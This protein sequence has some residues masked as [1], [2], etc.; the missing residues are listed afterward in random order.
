MSKMAESFHEICNSPFS[1]ANCFIFTY[2]DMPVKNNNI[3]LAY[4]V[5]PLVLYPASLN[6][7]QHANKTSSL[8]TLRKNKER[9]AGLPQ[10]ISYYKELTNLCLQYLMDN[11]LLFVDNDMSV[12]VNAEMK[13]PTA[14]TKEELAAT[15]ISLIFQ[16]IPIQTVYRQLGVRYL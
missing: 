2:K 8:L 6:F 14:R 5:L 15:K 11:N 7:L 9:I 4:L 12:H 1:L 10:R 3:L 13:I 16:D